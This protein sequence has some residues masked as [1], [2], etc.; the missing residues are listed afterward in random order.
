MDASASSCSRLQMFP[1]LSQAGW[2]ADE[3]SPESRIPNP[4]SIIRYT[5]SAPDAGRVWKVIGER[6]KRPS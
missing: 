6:L 5:I 4:E 3:A 2:N 1:S